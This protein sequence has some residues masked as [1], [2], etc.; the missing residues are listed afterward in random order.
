MT[1]SVYIDAVAPEVLIIDLTPAV[2]ADMDLST[3]SAASLKVQTPQNGYAEETWSASISNKTAT[4]LRLTHTFATGEVDVAGLYTVVAILTCT[5]GTVKSD[6]KSFQ[7][8][9]K[10]EARP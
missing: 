3:V 9:G 4:T 5:G 8:L 7:V 2:A 1:T 10:Y 6:P